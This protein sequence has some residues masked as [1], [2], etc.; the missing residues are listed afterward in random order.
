MSLHLGFG[1]LLGFY[2]SIFHVPERS[3]VAAACSQLA[4]GEQETFIAAVASSNTKASV[5]P[6]LLKKKCSCIAQINV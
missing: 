2:I 4:G 1:K 3:A 5:L 6:K